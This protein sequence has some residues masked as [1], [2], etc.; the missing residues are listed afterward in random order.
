[1]RR[2]PFIGCLPGP[3]YYIGVVVLLVPPSGVVV[4]L[5][6][7]LAPPGGVVVLLVVLL[8]SPSSVVVLL[9]VR[10]VHLPLKSQA[11]FFRWRRRARLLTKIVRALAV[12]HKP[13]TRS[14][15]TWQTGTKHSSSWSSWSS[16][17]SSARA[18]EGISEAMA[19]P[20]KSFSARR[21]LSEPSATARASSSN[22]R[23]V[24]SLLTCG[25]FPQGVGLGD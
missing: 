11:W 1:M 13:V 20:A 16:W 3:A 7:L 19:V 10:R 23:L 2:A 22:E 18:R 6:V 21:R 17:S 5:V 15:G 12:S 9:V 25:P 14:W 24:S 8:V 4:L